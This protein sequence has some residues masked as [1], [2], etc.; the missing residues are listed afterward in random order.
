[1]SLFSLDSTHTGT[2][3]ENV[4]TLVGQT[5]SFTLAAAV[6]ILVY[7]NSFTQEIST[8]QAQVNKEPT[9]DV[10]ALATCIAD[11]LGCYM[12]DKRLMILLAHVQQIVPGNGR[13]F[14]VVLN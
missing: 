4:V 13:S 1:M 12:D 9:A 11:V 6:P 7:C 3:P 5:A 2:S 10:L 14:C 8:Q